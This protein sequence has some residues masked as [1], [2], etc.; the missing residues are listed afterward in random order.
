MLTQTQLKP[1]PK[2][3]VFAEFS[4]KGGMTGSQHI[5]MVGA[6]GRGLTDWSRDML[7]YKM[8]FPIA[9]R[10]VRL[11]A[12]TPRQF[13]FTNR[14]DVPLFQLIALK[15][16]LPRCWP[17]AV[18]NLCRLY[19]DQPLGEVVY[20]ATRSNRRDSGGGNEI[21]SLS[22]R[23]TGLW[24]SD[25]RWHPSIAHLLSVDSTWLFELP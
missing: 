24:L 14:L 6:A 8:R 10:L 7:K 18:T 21:L 12:V 22:K 23:E 4:S 16:G 13:G 17:D 15:Q 25:F 3:E 20:V 5:A 19:Q 2:W 9:D 1:Q 11:V